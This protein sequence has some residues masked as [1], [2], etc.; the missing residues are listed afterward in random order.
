VD[1]VATA[2]AKKLQNRIADL[3]SI[4]FQSNPNFSFAPKKSTQNI[5]S[6][7]PVVVVPSQR[8]LKPDRR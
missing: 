4:P 5:L 6:F 1:E 8:K 2:L 3:I 7:Q